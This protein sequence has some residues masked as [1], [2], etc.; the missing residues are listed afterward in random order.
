GRTAGAPDPDGAVGSATC[1]DA[2]DDLLDQEIPRLFVAEEA[3]DVDENGVEQKTELLGMRLEVGL[4]V[5]VRVDIHGLQALLD[6]TH[7][8]RAL[9]GG[10]I[11]TT[12]ALEIVE[13]R[14]EPLLIRANRPL[15]SSRA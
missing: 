11:E 3:G 13:E 15:Q 7:E 5:V 10:E 12:A 14:L 8:T 4:I 9:V 2:R 1:E 6:P